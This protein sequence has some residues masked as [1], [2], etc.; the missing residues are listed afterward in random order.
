MVC[1]VPREEN[2]DE[3]QIPQPPA[4]PLQS[5]MN[6]GLAGAYRHPQ[7]SSYRVVGMA[8]QQSQLNRLPSR[9]GELGK[10]RVQRPDEFAMFHLRC[11]PRIAERLLMPANSY[12]YPVPLLAPAQVQ[13]HMGCQAHVPTLGLGII[14]SS[15]ASG[16][17][18]KAQ[19]DLLDGIISK[20]RITGEPTAEA[21]Q[22]GLRYGA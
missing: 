22:R 5:P 9:T 1:T 16:R 21:S 3:A 7:S 12:P 8:F 20:M 14:S 18:R 11:E 6:T 15:V 17:G 19:Q 2:G 10:G 4:Q 13:R